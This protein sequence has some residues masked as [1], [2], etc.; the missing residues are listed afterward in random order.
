MKS[1]PGVS[2]SRLT[3]ASILHGAVWMA[4]IAIVLIAMIVAPL[5]A[6]AIAIIAMLI[7]RFVPKRTPLPAAP[8]AKNEILEQ[9]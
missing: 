9:E 2:K 5:I 7:W 4:L 3:V 1:T 8:E 6:A